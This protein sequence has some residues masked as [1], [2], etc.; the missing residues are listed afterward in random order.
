MSL[1]LARKI[2]KVDYGLVFYKSE[3]YLVFCFI[4]ENLEDVIYVSFSAKG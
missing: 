2:S 3:G 4:I 1:E